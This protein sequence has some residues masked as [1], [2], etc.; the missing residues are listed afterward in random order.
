MPSETPIL[1]VSGLTVHRGAVPV[2]R[3]L[4]W[5]VGHG[6]MWTILGANGSGKTSLLSCLTGLLMPTAG[7]I[8]LLGGV[9]GETDWS[10]L[11]RRLGLVS[12]SLSRMVDDAET[13]LR[14]IASGASGQI[15]YWGKLTPG[16]TARARQLA[17][18]LRAQAA[19]ERPWAVL[20]QGERQ[21]ILIAR[22][23]MSAP[24]LLILDEPCAGL[25]PAARARL[26]SLLQQLQSRRRQPL[27]IVLV[28]HHLE[29]IPP[30][31][32]H[33]LILKSG[34]VLACGPIRQTLTSEHLS[35]A[36]GCPIRLAH[37]SGHWS[38]R[39]P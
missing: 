36:M 12:S 22:A 38:A 9:Y 14:V 29:E 5:T 28:T 19:L 31:C 11:R 23:L 18:L 6:E 13:G 3:G 37:H 20:S 26:L 16:T 1:S 17:R 27:S 25:D 2:L 7:R 4:D 32:T 10:A 33:V 39:L 24:R 8:E 21:R 35:A 34:R 30:G 15:N